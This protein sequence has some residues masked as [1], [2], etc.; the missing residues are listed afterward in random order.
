MTN[1]HIAAV[2]QALLAARANKTPTDPT[3]LLNELQSAQDAQAVQ[4]QVLQALAPN[5]RTPARY[6]K[7]G[8]PSRQSEIAN[9]A[10]LE[11]GI[12]SSPAVAGEHAFNIRLVEIEI[13]FKTNRS[14]TPQEATTMTQEDGHRLIDA[15]T[16]SIEVVDSRWEQNDK[17]SPLLKLADMQSHGA[18]VLGDWLPYSERE[19]YRDWSKQ[20]CTVKIGDHAPLE[21]VGTHSLQD[22]R[23][24]IPFWVRH[25]T[26]SNQTLPA[27]SI[28][29]TGSWCGMPAAQK[30]DL[31][32][33]Q[34][35]G[36]GGASV[37]L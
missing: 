37:Q 19:I 33:T 24:V 26:A 6:W 18:L 35:D 8:G 23:W 20:R 32:I 27:G 22:P 29:T 36:I 21:F 3:P 7:S 34:F 14:V 11:S 2:S 10:L 5:Q 4:E 30:G 1:P 13:A 25:A 15:L 16:V 17:A 12:W 28:V 31:V 9:T